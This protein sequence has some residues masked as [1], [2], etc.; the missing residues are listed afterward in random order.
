MTEQPDSTAQFAEALNNVAPGGADVD[1]IN[2]RKCSSGRYDGVEYT[3]YGTWIPIR[4]II[5]TVRE[6]ENFAIESMSFVDE[7]TADNDEEPRVLVFVADLRD[8]QPD[9]AFVGPSY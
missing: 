1:R 2:S 3:F 9:P 4:P 8:E 5:D 6:Q 7:S